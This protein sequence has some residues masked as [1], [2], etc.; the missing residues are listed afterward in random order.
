MPARSVNFEL[1]DAIARARE[2]YNQAWSQER[3]GREEIGA[4]SIPN[5]R[6]ETGDAG[7]NGSGIRIYSRFRYRQEAEVPPE[8]HPGLHHR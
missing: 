8:P 6:A 4:R 3:L 5:L 2:V 1:L 7:S